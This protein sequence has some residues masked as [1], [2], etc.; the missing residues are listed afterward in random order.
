MI[1]SLL[2]QL[3]L[4]AYCDTQ[5]HKDKAVRPLIDK[6]QAVRSHEL[7]EQ[8]KNTLLQIY[9]RLDAKEIET[10]RAKA[11]NL[12]KVE[13]DK[14]YYDIANETSYELLY[15]YIEA[16]KKIPGAKIISDYPVMKSPAPR[17][18]FWGRPIPQPTPLSITDHPEA[19]AFRVFGSSIEF[20]INNRLYRITP[21]L[22][23]QTSIHLVSSDATRHEIARKQCYKNNG[24]LTEKQI[25]K[26]CTDLRDLEE[27][28]YH[29]ERKKFKIKNEYVKF[30]VRPSFDHKGNGSLALTDDTIT[31]SAFTAVHTTA[32]LK[33]DFSNERYINGMRTEY[34]FTDGQLTQIDQI[35]KEVGLSLP[36]TPHI[37]T[38][39][40]NKA[41]N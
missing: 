36:Q 38:T 11:V 4:L 29:L 35:K 37:P 39:P 13:S 6:A 21:D 22:F 9:N 23:G 18:D 33:R 5:Y 20:I 30:Y 8:T 24:G 14:K 3:I 7:Q 17:K 28:E 25:Q 1:W 10:M 19:K 27:T 31:N 34:E 2:L 41:A 26:K 16:V 40:S 32:L 12:I 15:F